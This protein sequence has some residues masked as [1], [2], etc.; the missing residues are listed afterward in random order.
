MVDPEYRCRLVVGLSLQHLRLVVV[1]PL[2]QIP[3]VRRKRRK[4]RSAFG[5]F[6]PYHSV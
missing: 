3:R 1:V 6:L 2:P 4:R 5:Y